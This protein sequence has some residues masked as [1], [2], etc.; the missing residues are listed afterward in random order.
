MSDHPTTRDCPCGAGHQIRPGLL[1]CPAGWARLPEQLRERVVDTQRA[2]RTG[3]TG[4]AERNR[5]AVAAARA[6]L[7]D[8]QHGTA[9]AIPAPVYPTEPCR[10]CH[11]PMIWAVT[12]TGQRIP[13]DADP[14]D[15]NTGRGEVTLTARPG[16]P[17]LASIARHAGQ[18]F[19]AARVYRRHTTTCP[20]AARYRAAA[21]AR[22]I[23][24]REHA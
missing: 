20:Y 6:W 18:L 11:A 7:L 16:Y 5:A 10:S 3:D 21:R 24:S 19:G 22:G 9:S 15:V 12:T 4:A 2:R 17:P 13:V 14:V 23:R 1:V 8:H